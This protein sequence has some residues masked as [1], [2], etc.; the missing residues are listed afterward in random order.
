MLPKGLTEF[1]QM[2]HEGVGKQFPINRGWFKASYGEIYVRR[3]MRRYDSAE[4]NLPTFD[5]ANINIKEDKRGTHVFTDI[6]EELERLLPQHG[7]KM[8][9]VESIMEPRLVPFLRS[10]GYVE[11]K[12][13]DVYSVNMFKM[14]GEK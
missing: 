6:L 10:R 7:F 9:Y 4:Y 5:I 11:V 3:T 8:I 14:I 1:I 13:A 12:N 2:P